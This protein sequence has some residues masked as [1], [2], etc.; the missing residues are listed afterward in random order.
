MHIMR[1]KEASYEI[2]DYESKRLQ[3]K[4]FTFP[5]LL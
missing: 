1:W 5:P 2:V 3:T 4:T